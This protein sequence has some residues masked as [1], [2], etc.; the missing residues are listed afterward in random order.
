MTREE[1]DTI[2][3]RCEAATLGEWVVPPSFSGIC[4]VEGDVLAIRT[5]VGRN[6]IKD[7]LFIA[8][9]RQD[10]PALLNALDEVETAYKNRVKLHHDVMTERTKYKRLYEEMK[11][12]A[13]ALEQLMAEHAY[14][15]GGMSMDN[16]KPCPFCGGEKAKLFYDERQNYHVECYGCNKIISFH[17]DNNSSQTKAIEIWNRRSSEWIKCSDRLPETWQEVLFWDGMETYIGSLRDDGWLDNYGEKRKEV[18][19]W[20]SLPEPP[21]SE[22]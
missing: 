21:E 3:A 18:T 7:M 9:A 11:A 8:H 15:G 16:L 12:R 4:S 2:K 5:K 17:I 19:H 6:L 13:E 10:I 20:M 22:E 14:R 1:K